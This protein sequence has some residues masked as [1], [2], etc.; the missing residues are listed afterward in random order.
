[1]YLGTL[2]RAGRGGRGAF[3]C[4][5]F[6]LAGA[7]KNNLAVSV[8]DIKVFAGDAARHVSISLK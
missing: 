1:M 3:A 8:R 7:S 6:S 4:F 2:T 5:Q